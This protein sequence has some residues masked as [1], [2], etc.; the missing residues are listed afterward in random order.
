MTSHQFRALV[1]HEVD[2]L[3]PDGEGRGGSGRESLAPTADRE[4]RQ[5]IW[6]PRNPVIPFGMAATLIVNYPRRL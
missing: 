2:G 5:L 4:I 6:R 1:F 3:A